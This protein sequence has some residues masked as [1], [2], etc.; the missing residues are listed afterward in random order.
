MTP[1]EELRNQWDSD[2]GLRQ[3]LRDYQKTRS[4]RVLSQMLKEEAL[5][6]SQ[7]Y[8]SRIDADPILARNLVSMAGALG[9]L[10]AMRLATETKPESK[11]ELEEYNDE[12]VKKIREQQA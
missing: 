7:S 6:A 9:I 12:Y 2:A 5:E 4:W 10:E 3:E 11:P 1:A 8:N